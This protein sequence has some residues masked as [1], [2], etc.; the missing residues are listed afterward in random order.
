MIMTKFNLRRN[1]FFT[2]YILSDI[3]Y[4]KMKRDIRNIQERLN[5]VFLKLPKSTV[6]ELFD[7]LKEE[8]LKRGM[9]MYDE[10]GEPRIVNVRVRPWLITR[11][12]K[13]FFHIVCLNMK[14]ALQRVANIYYNEPKARQI[15]TLT[16]REDE[17]FFEI[18]KNGDQSQQTV[19]DR[20]DANAIFSSSDWKDSFT[21]I[22]TNSVGVGGVY[23]IP[24]AANIVEDIVL[25]IIRNHVH[26]VEFVMQD[27]IR[28]LLFETITEHAQ[29]I[30]RPR[31]NVVLIEDQRCLD[32]TDEY[33]FVANYLKGKGLT[34][35]ATD[36]REL[37]LRKGEVH[38]RDTPI[39]I[40]YRDCSIDELHEME[41]QGAKVD[42]L[43]EALR[44]NQ[45]V[46]SIAGEFDHKS[47]LE[48]F[49]D[50]EYGKYFTPVQRRLFKKHVV[51]TRLI[52]D[53]MTKGPDG[54]EIELSKF[55]RKRKDDLVIKPNRMYGG[56][57]VVLGRFAKAAEWRKAVENAFKEGS[58]HV[59]QE[60]AEIKEEK[61][62]VLNEDGRVT[63][64]K[65]YEVSGFASSD[66]GIAFLGRC[67]I[68]P[69]VNISRKGGLIPVIM[70]E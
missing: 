45:V 54:K 39:D 70:L 50:E 20:I 6:K 41:D 30:D 66:S 57:G 44:K 3:I 60:Y 9:V 7:R 49:T 56:E 34:A 14:D 47:T 2:W 24:A 67:S 37:T 26:K 1:V 27:D 13:R 53:R 15:L 17:W 43:K 4:K 16:S 61:F 28:E 59:V 33:A 68:E 52:W 55:I 38:F 35:F 19:F 18:Y 46:S 62:P 22:E 8:S 11:E 51:W 42:V 58:S 32:G 25:P 5:E 48:I 40:I 65:N 21:F 10:K 64:E 69:V 29:K 12:Q 23:Y 36:P 63:I 31:A